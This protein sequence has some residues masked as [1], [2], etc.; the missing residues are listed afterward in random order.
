MFIKSI[1]LAA[2]VAAAGS[3]ATANSYFEYGDTLKR[4]SVLDL[5]LVRSAENG[6]IEIY[7]NSRGELGTLLGSHLVHGGAN[8]NVR[9]NLGTQ[10]TQDVIAVLKIDGEIVAEREYDLNR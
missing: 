2:V 7:D 9:V 6:V 3:A 8:S 1:A 4:S 10:P 5:G